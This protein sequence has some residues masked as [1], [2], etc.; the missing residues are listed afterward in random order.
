MSKRVLVVEDDSLLLELIQFKLQKHGFH[1]DVGHDGEK[2]LQILRENNVDAVI[3]DLM[4]PKVDGFQLMRTLHAEKGHLPAVFIVVSARA[5][6]EDVLNAFELGAV[7]YMTKPFSLD[8]LVARLQIAL[9]F[10]SPQE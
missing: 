4:M 8:E 9:R 10:K 6:E 1:V 7:D 3:L 5:G 2:A